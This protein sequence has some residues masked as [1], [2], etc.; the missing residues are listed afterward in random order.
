MKG[1]ETF[2]F[3]KGVGVMNYH[4]FKPKVDIRSFISESGSF[5][6]ESGVPL[7]IVMLVIY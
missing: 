2:V 6:S 1:S 5:I 4:Y 3:F 7:F